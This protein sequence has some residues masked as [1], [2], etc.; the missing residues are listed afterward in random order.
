MTHIMITWFISEII[1]FA[2]MTLFV[3]LY[4]SQ[5]VELDIR[6]SL[7]RQVTSLSENIINYH[8]S[9]RIDESKIEKQYPNMYIA[10]ID[11]KGNILWGSVPD[12]VS[13]DTHRAIAPAK[14]E[15][16]EISYYYIDR[17][18]RNTLSDNAFV[19]AYVSEKDILRNYIPMRIIAYIGVAV[20]FIVL[21][22]VMLYALKRFQHSIKTMEASLKKSVLQ[23]WRINI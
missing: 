3:H 13:I 23:K 9:L 21:T 7:S 20:V 11:G 15:A 1:M 2:I 17:Y 14:I 16:K 6:S 19:R 8:G 22:M 5:S 10:V 4:I 18:T 12:G